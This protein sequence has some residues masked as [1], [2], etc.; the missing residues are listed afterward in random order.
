MTSCLASKAVN[1]PQKVK[2]RPVGDNVVLSFA[3][4]PSQ[5]F[6]VKVYTVSGQLLTEQTV[7][8]NGEREFSIATPAT[9]KVIYVV[10]ITSSEKGVTGSD[11]IRF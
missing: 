10:Q 9:S 11:I 5:S 6:N 3:N 7:A 4:V 2:I 1:S 8:A